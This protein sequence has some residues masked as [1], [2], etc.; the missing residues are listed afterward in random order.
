MSLVE[1]ILKMYNKLL[2]TG[3]GWA[4]K[5]KL[6]VNNNI[7]PSA[8]RDIQKLEKN[9]GVPFKKTGDDVFT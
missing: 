2:Q 1:L 3:I 4:T 5:P 6:Q 9:W 8:I 7:C